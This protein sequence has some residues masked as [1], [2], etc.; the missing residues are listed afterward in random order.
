MVSQTTL[1]MSYAHARKLIDEGNYKEALKVNDSIILALNQ[2]TLNEYFIKSLVNKQIIYTHICN[3]EK[4]ANIGLRANLL[5]IKQKDTLGQ[6]KITSNLAITYYLLRQYKTA[7]KFGE[8]SINLTL[9]L[10]S[11][12]GVISQFNTLAICYEQLKDTAKALY[13][14]TKALSF[15]KEDKSFRTGKITILQNLCDIYL[16]RNEFEKTEKTIKDIYQAISENENDNSNILLFGNKMTEYSYFFKLQKI[17]SALTVLRSAEEYI[18]DDDYETKK[19]Y[20][21]YLFNCF[22]A[23]SQ[24]DSA[25]KYLLLTS[26]A[27]DS[28][29][30]ASDLTRINNLTNNFEIEKNEILFNQKLA[31]EKNLRKNIIY[32]S[33]IILGLI[34]AFL[35]F[36]YLQLKKQ[37]RLNA[38]VRTQKD[39]LATKQQEILSSITYARRIQNAMLPSQNYLRKILK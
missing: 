21:E 26:E 14:Y 20:Y 7:I 29:Y 13:Y 8:Q 2:D 3:Y 25:L 11:K 9:S 23:K 1:K 24:K 10:K 31:F 19:N 12:Y 17:D 37:R 35:F 30:K 32:T 28:I 33:I 39:E 22:N 15:E 16:A 18:N 38:M 4:S 5:C 34:L 27:K 36:I 6:S